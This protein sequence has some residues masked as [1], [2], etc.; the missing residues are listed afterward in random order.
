MFVL[1][2][3]GRLLT[4]V[5]STPLLLLYKH[6][7]GK[8]DGRLN[9][10]LENMLCCKRVAGVFMQSSLRVCYSHHYGTVDKLRQPLDRTSNPKLSRSPAPPLLPSRPPPPFVFTGAYFRFLL[11]LAVALGLAH[12]VL[13]ARDATLLSVRP[14]VGAAEEGHSPSDLDG[15]SE[16]EVCEHL[17]FTPASGSVQFGLGR[18]RFGWGSGWFGLLCKRWLTSVCMRRCGDSLCQKLVLLVGAP[19]KIATPE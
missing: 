16:Q 4:Y 6:V 9:E 2:L 1:S 15:V 8:K 3:A 19:K 11:L 5:M 10:K 17:P 7:F 18:K 12:V 13:V 14:S